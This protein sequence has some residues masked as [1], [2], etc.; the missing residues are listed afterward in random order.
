MS[1]HCAFKVNRKIC[2]TTLHKICLFIIWLNQSNPLSHK[3][4]YKSKKWTHPCFTM[5]C[6]VQ[7]EDTVNCKLSLNLCCPDG[8]APL[9]AP[10][11]SAATARRFKARL[12]LCCQWPAQQE[13]AGYPQLA[14]QN[15]CQAEN[16][17]CPPWAPP[18]GAQRHLQKLQGKRYP[19]NQVQLVDFHPHEPVPAVPQVSVFLLWV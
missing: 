17:V 3:Q 4:Y 5:F 10:S 12:V 18:T 14:A 6:S 13:F 16:S 15:R 8:E 2:D 19:N 11:L 9:G 7:Y 1:L